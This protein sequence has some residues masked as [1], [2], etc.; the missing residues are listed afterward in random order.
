M[1]FILEEESG[2]QL[3]LEDSAKLDQLLLESEMLM[4][5][6]S[7]SPINLKMSSR[8]EKEKEEEEERVRNITVQ[9]SISE[10]SRQVVLACKSLNSDYNTSMEG[11]QIFFTDSFMPKKNKY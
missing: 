6:S 11:S 4:N 1:E 7:D 10:T 9:A 3:C 8:D 5:Q 2:R